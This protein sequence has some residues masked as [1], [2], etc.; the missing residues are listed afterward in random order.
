MAESALL[1]KTIGTRAPRENTC[2][3]GATHVGQ[4]FGQHVARFQIGDHQ[5]VR[6]TRYGRLDLFDSRRLLAYR[7]VN[8]SGPSITAPR[9]CPRSAILQRA[10]ASSVEGISI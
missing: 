2:G 7:I 6:H 4:L 5:N 1:V 8:A 10:A 3:F 9:I